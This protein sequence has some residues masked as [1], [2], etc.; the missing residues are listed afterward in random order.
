MESRCGGG[1]CQRV[2]GNPPLPAERLSKR[3]N[4]QPGTF[5]M[6]MRLQTGV[7]TISC[8]NRTSNL[9]KVSENFF[10]I[11]NNCQRIFFWNPCILCISES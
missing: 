5:Q 9:K 10:Y 1:G 6:D 3:G 4:L 7:P 2:W 11:K 8:K